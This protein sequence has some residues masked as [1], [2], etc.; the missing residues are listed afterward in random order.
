MMLVQG[1]DTAKIIDLLLARLDDLLVSCGAGYDLDGKLLNDIENRFAGK[2]AKERKP[3][4][5]LFL[6]GLCLL[7]ASC[8]E[9][10]QPLRVGTNV[11]P[12][13]EPLY[14]ARS[15]N[16]LS[17]Q[18]ARLVEYTSASQVMEALKDGA[19]QAA[20]LTLDET[21]LLQESG[22]DVRVVLV[23]DYSK[24]ADM[25]LSKPQ[26]EDLH[27][28]KGRR[29]GVEDT[30][31]GA[32][33]LD[34]AL[35]HAGMTYRDVKVVPITE[36]AHEQAYKSGKVDA[37]VTFDPVA[38]RLMT[39]GARKLFD[40]AQIPGE[41]VDVLVVRREPSG[42]PEA[43]LKSLLGAWY[44]GLDY[45]GKYPDKAAAL[46]A[47][48]MALDAAQTQVAFRG[49]HLPGRDENRK[50]LCSPDPML[51]KQAQKLAQVMVEHRLVSHALQPAS[52]IDEA[53]LK[54]L[55]P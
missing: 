29:I 44:G 38:S 36:Q 24:G 41:I 13:Y 7:L 39:A 1:A 53:L 22:L 20:A 42:Y 11:W 52:L 14:L 26:F 33:M 50:L 54:R 55:Y 30:A 40:S 49:I 43:Q 51:S 2:L 12:G 37:V 45:L 15:L 19:I 8:G 4:R 21:L 5:R 18:N 46:M 23:M 35:A 25:L 34:R 27:A 3:M 47:P 6:L 10:T 28:L 17:S 16:L 48:R 31:L 32:Y 9:P